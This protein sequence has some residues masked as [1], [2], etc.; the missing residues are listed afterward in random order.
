MERNLADRHL[1][2]AQQGLGF[3]DAAGERVAV[4]REAEGFLEL[5]REVGGG[6]V[7]HFSQ[8]FDGPF[9]V[10]GGVHAV[11]RAQEAA[12]EVGVLGVGGN[13]HQK[14]LVF[15]D[16]DAPCARTVELGGAH[17]GVQDRH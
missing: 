12:E 10:G 2:V 7:A 4:G 8:A 1:R 17:A 9:L 11:L 15:S 14:S 3:F 13:G 5:A 16:N 6:D